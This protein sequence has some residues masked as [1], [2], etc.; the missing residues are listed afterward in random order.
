MRR[1][2]RARAERH[3]SSVRL[4][5]TRAG[6]T[7]YN[8]EAGW[9]HVEGQPVGPQRRLGNAEATCEA[10]RRGAAPSRPRRG[11]DGEQRPRASARSEE[12]AR[13]SLGAGKRPQRARITPAAR[14]DLRCALRSPE[15][16]RSPL[17]RDSGAWVLLPGAA[18]LTTCPSAARCGRRK[19]IARAASPTSRQAGSSRSPGEALLHEG[20]GLR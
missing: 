5:T 7:E 14:H 19:T 1:A 13:R 9:G 4:A 2:C 20:A 12:G 15:D 8:A 18:D 17:G 6:R 16:I 11:G 3:P 10:H